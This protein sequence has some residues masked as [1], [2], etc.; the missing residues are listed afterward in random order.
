MPAGPMDANPMPANPI[1]VEVSRGSMV[2][3]RHRGAVAV[4]DAAGTLVFALGAIGKPVYPRS[5]IKPLQALALVETGAADAFGLGPEEVALACA[6]HSGEPR[7]VAGVEKWLAKIGCSPDDLECGPQAPTNEA[8]LRDMMRSGRSP[9][10]LQN[11]CSGKHAGFLSVARHLG[12]P[13]KGYIGFDH[14]VQ[15]LLRSILAAMFGTEL[16]NAPRG[17]DGCGIPVLAVPLVKIATAMARMA[18]PAV[19][20]ATRRKAALRIRASMAANPR[21]VGGTNRF[22]TRI[23]TETGENALIKGGAEGVYCGILPAAGVGIA[24]KIDDGAGRAAEVVMGGLL[25][26]FGALDLTQA[27]KL[28]GALEPAVRNWAGHEVGRIYPA[29]SLLMR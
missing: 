18:D 28:A 6:S 20:P 11:N 3:S 22:S 10:P 14:A 8:V 15:K 13:T 12:E 25:R 7:H 16:E 4:A 17:I 1:L 19:L 23:M 5:A 21:L 27:E 26:R 2:E 29:E 24:V 9:S